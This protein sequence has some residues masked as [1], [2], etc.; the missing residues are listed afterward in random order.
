M[1][2]KSVINKEEIS[3]I[4]ISN[5]N[6]N[7]AIDLYNHRNMLMREFCEVANDHLDIITPDV[8]HNIMKS[9]TF[10][11]IRETISK[12]ESLIELLKAQPVYKFKG[13]KVVLTG[14]TAEPIEFLNLFKEN[15]LA[16]VADDLGQES[17]QYRSDYPTGEDAIERLAAHWFDTKGCS[18]IYSPDHRERGK[19]LV[20]MAKEKEADCIAVCLM[21]FCDVEEYDYPYISQ[22]AE[23]AGLYSLCLEI[24]QSTQ[25]NGQSRTKIQSYAEI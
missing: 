12:M 19:M 7:A 22:M 15:N 18:T 25:D 14:I 2:G 16:V 17:R 8:R 6:L 10:T 3:G 13:K 9:A 4:E 21:R 23:E 24:D 1:I 5:E 20:E 11:E